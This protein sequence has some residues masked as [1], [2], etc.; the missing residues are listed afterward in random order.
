MA[1][2]KATDASA[3]APTHVVDIT[4][5]NTGIQSYETTPVGVWG[6]DANEAIAKNV[7]GHAGWVLRKVGSGGRAGRVTEETLVAMGSMTGDGADDSVYPDATITI[8]TQ[9]SNLSIVG[10][11]TA[12]FTVVTSVKPSGT[13]LSYQWYGPSG[14]ISG[15]TSAT[16]T[17]TGATSA[18]NGG[19]FANVSAT[20]ASTVTSANAV[21][22]VS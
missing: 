7:N 2:W 16:L 22:T 20:G 3:S 10:P 8:V 18:N 6:V 12:T 5:G 13:A 9:P 11:N 17:I 4:N 15:A 21:L 19:Y 14:L 1:L